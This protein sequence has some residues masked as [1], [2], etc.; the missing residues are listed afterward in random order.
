MKIVVLS[1]FCLCFSSSLLAQERLPDTLRTGTFVI[2]QQEEKARQKK[3]YDPQTVMM[4]SALIPG[5]GQLLNDQPWKVPLVYA[6]FLGTGYYLAYNS[7]RYTTYRNIV[8]Y[9]VRGNDDYL[10]FI[11]QSRAEAL[12]DRFRRDLELS[13]IYVA[14]WYGLTV[15]DALVFAHLNNFDVDESLSL[16]MEPVISRP[17]HQLSFTGVGLSLRF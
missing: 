13:I 8:A 16:R 11:T 3:S 10:S 4:Y 7:Q 1:L 2:P 9:R 17:E 14:V 5:V 15:V 12:R 6:G